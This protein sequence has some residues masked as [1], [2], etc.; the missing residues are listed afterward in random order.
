MIG[1]GTSEDLRTIVGDGTAWTHMGEVLEL[2]DD[3]A[4]GV[5]LTVRIQP[6]GDII[7]ARPKWTATGNGT[8]A[9]WPITVGD[10][11]LVEL[12]EGDPLRAVA[13]AGWSS[14]PAAPPASWDNQQ[15]QFVHGQGVHFRVSGATPAASLKKVVTEDLLPAELSAWTELQVILA[16]L[17]LPTTNIAN[18]VSQLP[19]Q[20]RSTAIKTE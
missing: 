15:P 9:F 11:V 19:T 18:L 12:P 7:T 2:A 8:G 14:T 5:A 13:Q 16:A 10:E 17:G 6:S 3:P 20:F 4:W 1:A